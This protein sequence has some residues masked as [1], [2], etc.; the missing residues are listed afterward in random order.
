MIITSSCFS[1]IDICLLSELIFFRL[2]VFLSFSFLSTDFSSLS[3]FPRGWPTKSENV[4]IMCQ[5][6]A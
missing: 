6:L 4:S 3:L 1:L 5:I 2:I